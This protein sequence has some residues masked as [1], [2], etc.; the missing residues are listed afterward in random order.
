M[1]K[2]FA[3]LLAFFVL[4]QALALAVGTGFIA[5]QLSVLE[6]PEDPGNAVTLLLYVLAAAAVL[7]I[8]LKFYSGNLL[9][10]ALEFLL[11]LFSTYMALQL[12]VDSLP[13]LAIGIAAGA[14]RFLYPPA[15]SYLLLLSAGVAGALLGSSLDAIP[16]IAFA[17]LLSVYDVLAVFYTKHMI[18]LAQG[19]NDRGTSFSIRITVPSL[20]TPKNSATNAKGKQASKSS[21]K[22]S[23]TK[24]GA[25]ESI[26]LG[27]GDIVIP[28]MIMVAA[29]KLSLVQA[30]AALAGS[31]VGMLLLFWLMTRRRGYWP[32]LP[33]IV[34]GS[35]VFLAAA[36][37]LG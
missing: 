34:L 30:G 12:L 4:A 22:K 19:L 24:E 18:T 5:Q 33:P 2:L 36:T 10:Q 16:A 1:K 37:L 26:E 14:A 3:H 7:L 6:H 29:A 9:F 28:A 31:I 32:A 17:T 21:A 27:T 20:Q 15:R 8:I 25:R 11:V 35:L 23:T 13:A